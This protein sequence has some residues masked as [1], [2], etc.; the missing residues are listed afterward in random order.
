MLTGLL[1]N[2][3][4]LSYFAKKRETEAMIVQ[5]LGVISTYVLLTQLAM[6]EAMPFH[7]FVLTSVAI[8]ACLFFNFLHYFGM[9]PSAIWNFWDYFILVSGFSVLAQVMVVI[10]SLLSVQTHSRSLRR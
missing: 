2:L 9:L 6:A 3:S 1:G 5:C 4:L 10:I 8:T 7:Y